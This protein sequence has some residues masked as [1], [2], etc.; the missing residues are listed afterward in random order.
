[1]P[2]QRDKL[3]RQFRAMKP[4]KPLR[5]QLKRKPPKGYPYQEDDPRWRQQPGQGQG[6]ERKVGANVTVPYGYYGKAKRKA[7]MTPVWRGGSRN[8]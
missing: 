1:M 5:S 3:L 4:I 8:V 2:D 7:R 6:Q